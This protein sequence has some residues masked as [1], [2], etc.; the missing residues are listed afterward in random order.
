VFVYVVGMSIDRPLRCCNP[1]VRLN[2]FPVNFSHIQGNSVI[3]GVYF[4][5]RPRYLHR[6]GQQ[7]SKEDKGAFLPDNE[8]IVG[9]FLRLAIRVS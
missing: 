5:D 8:H 2:G 9:N 4:P 1:S 7:S 3:H 6:F